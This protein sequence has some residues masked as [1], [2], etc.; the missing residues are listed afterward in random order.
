M[1]GSL[2][3]GARFSFLSVFDYEGGGGVSDP[4][5]RRGRLECKEAN[6]SGRPNPSEYGRRLIYMRICFVWQSAAGSRRNP[7]ATVALLTPDPDSFDSSLVS[8]IRPYSGYSILFH[9][10]ESIK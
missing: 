8:H 6:Y 2:E 9:E 4:R 3:V 7:G 5:A 10:T 1:V